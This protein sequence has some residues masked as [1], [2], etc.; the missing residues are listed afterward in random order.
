MIRQSQQYNG[1]NMQYI[2]GNDEQEQQ[3]IQ[4]RL[5]AVSNNNNQQQEQQEEETNNKYT[6]YPTR[7]LMLA[8]MSILNRLKRPWHDWLLEPAILGRFGLMS[9]HTGGIIIINVGEGVW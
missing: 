1:N 6:I 8:Y 5:V 3:Q 2:S 4:D 7:Y 9:D